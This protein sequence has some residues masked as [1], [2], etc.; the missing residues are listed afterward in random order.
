[1]PRKF[2]GLWF[3]VLGL[4]VVALILLNLL[5]GSVSIP[6]SG[7]LDILMNPHDSPSPQI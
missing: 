5:L 3:L 1:M 7:V 4:S 2:T 6:F